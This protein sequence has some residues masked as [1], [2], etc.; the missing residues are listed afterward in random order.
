MKH[1]YHKLTY[2]IHRNTEKA[3]ALSCFGSL[4]VVLMQW[5]LLGER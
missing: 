3:I 1:L 5:Y 4:L 2:W